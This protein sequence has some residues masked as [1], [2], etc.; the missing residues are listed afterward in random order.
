[1]MVELT[2]EEVR[3]A[4]ARAAVEKANARGAPYGW[5]EHVDVFGL[6]GEEGVTARLCDGEQHH[7]ALARKA[8]DF[9]LDGRPLLSLPEGWC[10]GCGAPPGYHYRQSCVW[11]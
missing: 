5:G 11:R 1:M 7:I 6:S 3:R 2:A 9:A 4:I 8:R 10:T